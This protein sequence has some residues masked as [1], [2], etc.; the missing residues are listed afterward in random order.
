MPYGAVLG[1]QELGKVV[2]HGCACC[3]IRLVPS[4]C[5]TLGLTYFYTDRI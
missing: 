4:S 5:S 2:P 1:T 3:Y